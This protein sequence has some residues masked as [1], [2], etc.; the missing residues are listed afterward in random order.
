METDGR[1]VT[2]LYP[3]PYSHSCD[4]TQK[5][6][7]IINMETGGCDVTA[8]SQES[9]LLY[10]AYA[11]YHALMFRSNCCLHRQGSFWNFI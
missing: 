2:A 9:R 7:C 6:S 11:W 1:D 4:A 3:Y 8:V 10:K 5:L